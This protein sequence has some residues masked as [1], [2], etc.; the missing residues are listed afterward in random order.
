MIKKEEL[1][2][3]NLM[4]ALINQNY[5][6]MDRILSLHFN[7]FRINKKESD[8]DAFLL[9]LEFNDA[10]AVDLIF[11]KTRKE[12]IEDVGFI[13]YKSQLIRTDSEEI[14]KVLK[15]HNALAYFSDAIYVSE[16]VSQIS[17][18]SLDVV[19]N[20]FN[21][22][23]SSRDLNYFFLQILTMQYYGDLKTDTNQFKKVL[24]IVKSENAQ[25]IEESLFLS[26]LKVIEGRDNYLQTYEKIQ[27]REVFNELIY[28]FLEV[29]LDP[30]KKLKD[31][32]C[33]SIDVKIKEVVGK[34][35]EIGE[36]NFFDALLFD[37]T[38]VYIEK[39]FLESQLSPS[40]KL[41]NELSQKSKFKI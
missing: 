30:F 24:Q 15:K 20:E 16:C 33:D 27:N 18:N 6:V 35:P 34:T 14:Y 5:E 36:K 9:A 38:R 39:K 17:P 11:K 7:P 41:L 40:Q 19:L 13:D 12:F 4:N 10:R 8:T 32:P 37:E 22:K 23:V 1:L 21:G 28:S 31:Y 25:L 29:G 3:N 26:L 2:H